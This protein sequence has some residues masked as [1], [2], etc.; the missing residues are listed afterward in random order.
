MHEAC[1]AS[2]PRYRAFAE[3]R[4]RIRNAQLAELRARNSL[5]EGWHRRHERW[6]IK[7]KNWHSK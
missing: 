3:E 4:E 1:H 5:F 7:H 2:C 6:I